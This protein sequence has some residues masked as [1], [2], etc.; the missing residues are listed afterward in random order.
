MSADPAAWA[1]PSRISSLPDA[2]PDTSPETA[3]AFARI[4]ASRGWLSNQLAALG[5]APEA[6]SCLSE[7]GHYS[8]YGAALTDRQRELAICIAVRDAHYAWTHHAL[9]ARRA[10]V[11]VAELAAIKDGRV[12]ADLS[13]SDEALCR[14]AFA[15]TAREGTPETVWAAVRPHFT[16]R[17]V[18][19]IA[20]IVAY[21]MATGVLIAALGVKLESEDPAEIERVWQ[22]QRSQG[23][24]A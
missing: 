8:R 5:H 3:A 23:S 22:G 18:T 1:G 20:V 6:L 21:Y 10:G 11:T 15:V 9:L 12:P 24:G 13:P 2:T 17:E 16:P 19:D 7:I 4:T 14:L